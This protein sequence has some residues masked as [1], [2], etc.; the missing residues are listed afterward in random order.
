MVF[1]PPDKWAGGIPSLGHH[2]VDIDLGGGGG[3]SPS[4]H[5]LS[6]HPLPPPTG[7]ANKRH[8]IGGLALLAFS[9]LH[10]TLKKISTT[11]FFSFLIF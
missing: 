6:S 1:P 9:P 11:P 5:F 3:I 7:Q 10:S 4:F 2:A 8:S